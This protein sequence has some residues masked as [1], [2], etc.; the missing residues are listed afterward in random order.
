MTNNYFAIERGNKCLDRVCIKNDN[1]DLMFEDVMNMSYADIK[2]YKD[3][4]AFVCSIMDATNEIFKESDEQ[5]CVTLVGE[6]DVFIWGI[7]VGPGDDEQINYCLVD[8]K[9]DG[10]LYRYEKEN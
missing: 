8:W 6:D 10:R 3:I 5:T 7:L 4:D 1:G 2:E 9:K